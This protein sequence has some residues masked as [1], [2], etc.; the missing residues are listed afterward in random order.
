MGM[1]W[2]TAAERMCHEPFHRPPSVGAEPNLALE[3]TAYS[4]RSFLASAFGGGSLRA[5][6]GQRVARPLRMRKS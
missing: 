2:S 1:R 6:G 4:L 3:P 5:L